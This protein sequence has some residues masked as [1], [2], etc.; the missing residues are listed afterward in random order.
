MS[1][2]PDRTQDTTVSQ[3]PGS[4][5]AARLLTEPLCVINVGLEGFAQELA[6]QDVAVVHVQWSPPADGDPQ[7][8]H[9]LAE[10]GT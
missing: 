2:P 3:P 10:L 1:Q 5:P 6:S 9:L 4:S 7:L 8:A